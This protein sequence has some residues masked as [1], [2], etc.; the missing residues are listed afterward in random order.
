MFAE[1]VLRTG[2]ALM[3]AGF[4]NPEEHAQ[5]VDRLRTAL[6]PLFDTVTPMPYSALNEMFDQANCW[7]QH[8]FDNSARH[9][10]LTDDVIEV[11]VTHVPRRTSPLSVVMSYHLA[12]AFCETDPDGTAFGGSRVRQY[13]TF[14][15]GVTADGEALPAERAWARSLTAALQPFALDAGTT[16]TA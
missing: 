9:A 15:I 2:F 13:T 14:V 8:Y 1:H 10:D 11:L 6:P 7:G 12:E 4:G 5:A 3:L 16:S